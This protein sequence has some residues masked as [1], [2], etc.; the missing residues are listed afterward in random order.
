MSDRNGQLRKNKVGVIGAVGLIYSLTAA[1]AYGCEDMI[2]S[3]GPGLTLILLLILPIFWGLPQGLMIAELGSALPLEG[4]G[5][6]WVQRSMGEFWSFQFGWCR[7][8]GNYL[9]TPAF[10]ILVGDYA[11]SLFGLNGVEKYILEILLI[12]VVVYINIRGIKEVAVINTVISLLIIVAF[13]MVAI[14]GFINF[15]NNPF[16]PIIP[17]EQSF[18]SS[19]GVGLA[20][21]MWMYLGFYSMSAVAG[22]LENPQVIPKAILIVIPLM[23]LTYVLPTAAGVGSIGNW[24]EWGTDGV[25]YANVAITYGTPSLGIF[26]LF[27]ALAS[28]L[29][30]FNAYTATSPREFFV[31]SEDRLGPSFFAK[32]SLKH[33]T[34]ARAIVLMGVFS[35]ACCNFD[36]SSI[37]I[38]STFMLMFCIV[39]I[40][41]SAI[42]LRKKEPELKGPFRTPLG[43]KGYTVMCS[44]PIIISIIAL[45]LNGTD[46]FVFGLAAMLS[47]IVIYVPIKRQLGGR[48]K[49][50]AASNPLNRRSRLAFGDI[51]RIAILLIV[52]AVIGFVGRWFLPLYEDPIYY[53]ETYGVGNAFELFMNGL[54][55]TSLICGV[56][57]IV[58]KLVAYKVEVPKNKKI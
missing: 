3:T 29:S 22:E 51:N 26:F 38:I 2:P 50:D 43:D 10:I 42:L 37:V 45:Y 16:D 9:G 46:Y 19:I 27:I 53:A 49:I 28:Q 44:L 4:G 34:P 1:G 33:G 24:Q 20:I 30:M 57:G 55:A 14:I 47:G 32:I 23:V 7:F 56:S 8:L 5:Y 35:I 18:I 52:L 54:L 40:S 25:S 31:I 13:G 11:A 15:N 36:F 41:I 48:H 21:G 6:K 17:E 58:L 12:I 39:L